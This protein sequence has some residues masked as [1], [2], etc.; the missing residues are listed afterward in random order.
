MHLTTQNVQTVEIL[1]MECGGCLSGSLG[2]NQCSMKKV[3]ELLHVSIIKGIFSW[4]P[5]PPFS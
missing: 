3:N 5:F 2:M 1:A 4:S